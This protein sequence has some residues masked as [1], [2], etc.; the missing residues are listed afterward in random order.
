M[1]TTIPVSNGSL[2]LGNNLAENIL[3]SATVSNDTIYGY[4]GNDTILGL[5][6]N[7]YIDGGIGNDTLSGG[8]GNDTLIGGAGADT[9]LGDTGGD[10]AG[11]PPGT[12]FNDLI[13]GGAGNDSFNGGAGN[14]TLNGGNDN[15]IL[16]GA[17]GL[18]TLT[19][20]A[21]NDTFS[22]PLFTG[23]GNQDLILDFTHGED[24]IAISKAPLFFPTGGFNQDGALTAITG[25]LPSSLFV[26]G[27]GLTAPTNATQRFIFDTTTK[28][29]YFFNSTVLPIGTQ[30]GSYLIA[31][32]A[33]IDLTASDLVIF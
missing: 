29:L 16:I 28:N 14:D 25:T 9:I 22:Y 20:G 26:S 6:G 30:I 19:G 13:F 7:D 10:V 2:I 1:A 15:D 31:T 3:A 11:A 17:A 24:I 5:S 4:A 27:A 32:T 12:T 21:G 33:G 8:R 23:A 18:D